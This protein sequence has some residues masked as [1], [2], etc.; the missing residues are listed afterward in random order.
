MSDQDIKSTLDPINDQV[1][2][3]PPEPRDPDNGTDGDMA[4]VKEQSDSSAEILP[5]QPDYSQEESRQPQPDYNYGEGG[6]QPQSDYSYGQGQPQG[7][8]P[9]PEPGQSNSWQNSGSRGQ[10]PPPSGYG[11]GPQPGYG[12]GPGY[13]QGQSQNYKNP[14]PPRK[15]SNNMATASLVMGIL[16]VVLCCCGGFGIILGAIGIVLAILSRGREPMETSAKVGIG[17]SVGGIVLSIIVL[18]MTFA[19][20]GNDGLRSEL[21]NRGNGN[22]GNYENFEHY[23]EHNGL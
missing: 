19:V 18:V 8:P 22:Y 23:F 3:M 4:A 5:E 16:S 13:G 21:Y 17:L 15:N 10:V 20:I 14:R 11:Q 7:H 1:S 2:D 12:Y 9:Y 6:Q